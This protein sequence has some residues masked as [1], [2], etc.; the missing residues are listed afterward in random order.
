MCV[1]VQALIAEKVAEDE[2]LDLFR[3][4]T[5]LDNHVRLSLHFH[6]SLLSCV[7]SCMAPVSSQTWHLTIIPYWGIIVRS[8]LGYYCKVYMN[9]DSRVY[10]YIPYPPLPSLFSPHPLL[11]GV[12]GIGPGIMFDL[13][14]AR[15]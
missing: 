5:E 8:Q 11:T 3:H 13:T 12:R 9:P 7:V 6:S 4:C 14:D 1:C 10:I 15:R 2:A